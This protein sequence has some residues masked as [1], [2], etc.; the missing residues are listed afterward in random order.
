MR[1]HLKAGA[2]FATAALTASVLAGCGSGGG[3]DTIKIGAVAG[4]T[5]QF[6]TAEVAKTAQR[7]FDDAND[8]GGIN[9]KKIEYIVKD[10]AGNPQR[11][12][13]VARE[14]ADTGVV[15][16]A[17][18]ASF[19]DCDVNDGFYRQQKLNSV[20]A[21]AATPKCF[22]SPNIA[23]VN[24]GPF[25]LMTAV[26]LHASQKLG[27]KNICNFTS[28]LPGNEEAVKEALTRWEK[29]S[30][31]TLKVNDLTVPQS[32][33]LTPYLLKAKQA[34]CDAILFNPAESLVVPWLQAAK[35]QGMD[36]VDY[37]LLAPAYTDSVAK[38]VGGLGL[39]VYAGSEFEPFTSA[40]LANKGWRDT[41]TR[42][43][44]QAT[45]FSQ[46]GYLAAKFMVDVLK[47]IKGD[48]TR[49]TVGAALREMTPIE[50]P[51]LGT[52]WE[53]GPGE[54]HSP[55]QGSKIVRLTGLRWVVVDDTFI[56]VP[57]A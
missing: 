10:D 47:T 27:D 36:D 20:M 30:G 51:M 42:A 2:V 14:L 5:G 19:T 43:D 29:I 23:P 22:Q 50:D 4:L 52:P 3:G 8:K 57:N 16:M 33:D 53:F 39:N 25:T 55:N 56:T 24:V 15:A 17:G 37:L 18:S 34:D 38:A 6:I 9:G 44:A 26:L 31:Q 32:G 21:V 46:G 40:S 1:K 54:S 45:A 28:L 12:A 13:Q 35:T 48:V 49:E 41:V 11:T 7:V